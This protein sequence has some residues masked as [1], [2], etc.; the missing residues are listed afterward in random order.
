MGVELDESLL[1]ATAPAPPCAR[2]EDRVHQDMMFLAGSL[3]HRSAQTHFERRAAEH[4]RDRFREN[5]PD[6]EV[7]DFH[8]IENPAYLFGSY[9]GEFV[10]VGILAFGWPLFAMVYGAGVLIAFLAEFHGIQLFGRLLP[11][12]ET[13]N[14][15]ARFLSLR[16]K[17]LIIVTAHYD[18]GGASPLS[19]PQAVP[20]LRTGLRV[21][22][23]AMVVVLATCGA[24]A[25]AD[26][27]GA[28]APWLPYLRWAA[29]AVLATGAAFLFYSSRQVEDIRGA[30]G[31]ASGVA[32]L[33]QLAERF[34]GHGVDGA[35]VW[36]AA[37]G[38][39]EAW[40]SGA[41]R[42][43]K[44]AK[45]DKRRIYVLNIESV[46]AGALHYTVREG[47]LGAAKCGKELTATAAACAGDF[48]AAPATM[49]AVPTGAHL[50]LALGLEAMSIIGLNEDGIPANWNQITDRI[51][52]IDDINIVHA[53]DFAEAVVR[54]LAARS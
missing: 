44:Q 52:E 26:Y 27:Q 32:A 43:L 17:R 35:D 29:I 31:N 18:S 5:T 28:S 12:Y 24:E 40:M 45:A 10:V 38:S 53:A 6:V 13:Q 46:G 50:P 42:L 39:H 30:N 25:W 4:I 34:K 16:P 54:G 1:P 7:D 15:I 8:A 41:R 36:L 3:L 9:F 47:L 37:T 21:L 11:E 20:W 19:D 51:M 23:G 22:L 14:V 48:G 49:Q 2:P 33:L